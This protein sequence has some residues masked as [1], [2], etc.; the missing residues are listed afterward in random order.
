M[1]TKTTKF[2]QR[3]AWNVRKQVKAG[4]PRG[5]IMKAALNKTRGR[6]DK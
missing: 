3:L 4:T 2:S 6:K 5:Q 1:S